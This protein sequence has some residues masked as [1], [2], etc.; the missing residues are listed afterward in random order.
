M[1][2]GTVNRLKYKVNGKLPFTNLVR[3]NRII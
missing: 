3:Q 1:F 2:V